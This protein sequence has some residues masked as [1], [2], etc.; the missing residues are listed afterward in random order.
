VIDSKLAR[1]LEVPTAIDETGLS[2][3]LAR[4]AQRTASA[5]PPRFNRDSKPRHSHSFIT[6]VPT[7]TTTKLP[8]PADHCAAHTTQTVTWAVSLSLKA[9]PDHEVGV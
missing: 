6:S 7:S 8:Q 9:C 1:P 3:W 5:E 2:T 4:T